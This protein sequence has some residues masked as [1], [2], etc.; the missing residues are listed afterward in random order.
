MGVQAKMTAIADKIRLLLGISGAM[1]LDAM[2][3]NLETEHSNVSGAFAAI[4][5][6]GGSVPELQISG[7]LA[8]AIQSIPEG[9]TIQRASGTVNA[10]RREVTVNCGFQPDI[11]VINGFDYNTDYGEY[12]LQ[13]CFCFSE[14]ANNNQYMVLTCND[15]WPLIEA[16]I[17]QTTTGFILSEFTGYDVN[18]DDNIVTSANYS[19]VAIKYT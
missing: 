4:E 9:A 12:Q 3:E 17:R 10:G 6:R 14:K 16:V 7:N 1:G 13:M 8:E 18:W 2:A 19:Y 15:N 11:V 5:A